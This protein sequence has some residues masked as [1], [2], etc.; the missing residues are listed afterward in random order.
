MKIRPK[1]GTMIAAV[2]TALL[3]GLLTAP[4]ASAW[5]NSSTVTLT[6]TNGCGGAQAV[7]VRGVFNEQRQSWSYG[8]AYTAYKLTFTNVPPDGGWAWLWSDCAVTADHG[9]WVKVYRPAWGSTI[10]ANLV[11]SAY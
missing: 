9:T 10:T 2:L 6:G 7:T 3:M 5:S 8:S 11:N 1:L 4:T